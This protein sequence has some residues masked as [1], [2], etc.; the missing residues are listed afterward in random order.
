MSTDYSAWLTQQQAAQALNCSTKTVQKLATA[1]KLQSKAG[2][3]LHDGPGLHTVYH[4][5]DVEA[6]R[7]E[8]NPEAPPF[9]LPEMKP[10]SAST[11]IVRRQP[12]STPTDLVARLLETISETSKNGR[13]VKLSERVYLTLREASEYSGLPQSWI[14]REINAKIL[15]AR[16]QEGVG[17]RIKR[18][19]LEAL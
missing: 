19:D 12:L 2:V 13:T 16:Y 6:L 9:L 1:G 3:K 17:Y 15:G 8:R 10:T 4:P 14:M 5:Q 11:A 18:T 7:K